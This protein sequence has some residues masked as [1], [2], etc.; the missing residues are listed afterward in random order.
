MPIDW[1]P[2]KSTD[3]NRMLADRGFVSVDIQPG[4]KWH[5]ALLWCQ[6]NE[7]PDHF[8]WVGARTFWFDN[9]KTATEFALRCA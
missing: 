3:Y 9:P 7:G 1:D 8:T 2:Q 5:A 6:Q 4:A